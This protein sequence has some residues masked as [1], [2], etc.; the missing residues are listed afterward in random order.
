M[1]TLGKVAAALFVAAILGGVGSV[2][3]FL[4]HMGATAQ[5]QKDAPIVAAAETG[6]AQ[7]HVDAAATVA[8]AGLRQTLST[9]TQ[10]AHASE[11]AIDQDAANEAAADSSAAPA[12]VP[13]D[14]D[15][16]WRAGIGRLR[17]PAAGGEGD[18]GD[19]HPSP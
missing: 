11:Q 15:A 13:A 19:V 14:M 18:V 3:W 8:S 4:E 16:D 6:G 7:A 12:L 2:V 17:Q 10:R 9:L 5:A 1:S